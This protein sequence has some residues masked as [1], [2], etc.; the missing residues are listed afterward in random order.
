MSLPPLWVCF[1]GDD[2]AF[3]VNNFPD[4]DNIDDLCGAIFAKIPG[5]LKAKRA[6]SQR[7]YPNAEALISGSDFPPD[8]VVCELVP[9]PGT[10]AA[11]WIMDYRRGCSTVYFEP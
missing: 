1:H 6:C 11:A 3:Q 2:R 4:S 5:H 8:A 9:K 10:V 7:V